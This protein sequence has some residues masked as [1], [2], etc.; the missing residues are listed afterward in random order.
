MFSSRSD[1]VPSPLLPWDARWGGERPSAK[2]IAIVV[3]T[4]A[5]AILGVPYAIDAANSGNTGRA[6]M[7]V[8]ITLASLTLA[9]AVAPN[10]RVRRR[11]LPRDIAPSY[12]NEGTPGLRIPFRSSWAVVVTLWLTATAI[13]LVVRAF[14]FFSHLSSD[15]NSGRSAIDTGGIVIAVIAVALAAFMIRYLATRNNRRGRVDLNEEGICLALG[16]AV[17]SIAWSD[18]GDISPFILNNSRIIRIRPRTGQKIRVKIGKSLL[19]RMQ[20]G[21]YEQNMDLHATV[22]DIDSALLLHL[23][24]FYWQHL[25]ART[26]LTTDAVID[27]IQRGE[28][29]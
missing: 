21:Y 20:R 6:V 27:R 9:L 1:A 8:A 11:T 10:L 5:I 14:L 12:S 18:I 25:E 16:S 28:L 26:E 7:G 24:Q 13:F 2:L 23:T 3:F 29:V 4:L 17:R 15:N 22:L 19:D